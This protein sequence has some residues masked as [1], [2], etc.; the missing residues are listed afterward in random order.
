MTSSD[1]TVQDDTQMIKQ[2]HVQGKKA[3][4]KDVSDFNEHDIKKT[5]SCTTEFP[6]RPNNALSDVFEDKLQHTGHYTD[7]LSVDDLKDVSKYNRECEES[8]SELDL[9]DKQCQK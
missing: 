9:S 3:I 8:S 7:V 4:P 6:V 5:Q 1:G 2:V